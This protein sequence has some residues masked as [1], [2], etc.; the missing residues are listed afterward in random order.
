MKIESFVVQP[1]RVTYQETVTGTH[2]ILRLRTDEGIEGVS[3]VSRIGGATIRPLVLLI[4]HAAQQVIG[5]DPMNAE[6]LYARAYRVGVGGLPSGL[7]ARAASAIDAAAWD[8]RGKALGQP[9][10]RLLGGFRDRVPVSANWGVQSGPDAETLAR[11]AQDLIGRG[12]RTLKFQLGFLDRAAAVAHMRLMRQIVGNDI[13]LIVDANLQWTVKRAIAMGHALAEYEP[14]WIEDPVPTHEYAG[15]RQVRDAL[16]TRIC[17]GEVLQNVPPFRRLLEERAVDLVMIDLDLGLTGFLK[18]AHLAEAYG[19][20]VVNHLAS[21]ILAHGV[22]AVP[23]GLIVG[24]YPWAQPLFTTPARIQ[25]GSLCLPETPGLGLDLDQDAV[26]R[27][28]LSE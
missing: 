13:G 8:I 1:V 21:E 15:L 9:V 20:P 27:F 11:R 22:A 2:V 16:E 25:D 5:Q 10:W 7:E 18:V 4:E 14:F 26:Q 23:N 19:L 3:F 28:A 12:F 6:A 17:A 24:F